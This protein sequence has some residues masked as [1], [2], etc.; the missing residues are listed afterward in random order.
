MDIHVAVG[1]GW[2][3]LVVAQRVLGTVFGVYCQ[4]LCS[5]SWLM[6]TQGS[7]CVT[8]TDEFR[9]GQGDQLS[10]GQ[11]DPGNNTHSSM[12]GLVHP[13]DLIIA[14]DDGVVVI[15]QDE[16]A[17]VWRKHSQGLPM[18]KT[19]ASNCRGCAGPGSLQD[20]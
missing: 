13:G 6:M 5:W 17:Q 3:I 10:Y 15:R 11:R 16:A 20:A 1:S 2:D 9:F 12:C 4:F 8:L 18:K 7:G 19:S 14:D